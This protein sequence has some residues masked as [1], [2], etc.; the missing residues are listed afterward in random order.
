MDGLN[1][2]LGWTPSFLESLGIPKTAVIPLL[3]S[4]GA[5]DISPF[6]NPWRPLEPHESL[7]GILRLL[8]E[9]VGG[10]TDYVK[11]LGFQKRY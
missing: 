11:V 5:D 10:H 8:N 7:V 6:S 2:V 9:A 3:G 1:C 4:Q